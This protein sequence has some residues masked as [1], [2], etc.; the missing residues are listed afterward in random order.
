MGGLLRFY[1]TV[2]A[3]IAVRLKAYD[4]A[5]ELYH[6]VEDGLGSDLKAAAPIMAQGHVWSLKGDHARAKAEFERALRLKPDEAVAH[7]NVGWACDQQGDMDAALVHF[8]RA[9]E[10]N[11]DLDRAWY[12][13][14]VIYVRREQ[15]EEAKKAFQEVVAIEPYNRYGW[16]QLGMTHFVL[17]ETKE[18][19]GLRHHTV[20]FDPKISLY[21]DRDTAKLRAQ[22]KQEQG[23][24]KPER[25][26]AA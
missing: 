1:L 15:H 18:L 7:F 2:A 3:R 10:L 9:I 21:I 26:A 6:S 19:D 8:K 25:A 16:Y 20:R 14:G 23:L 12:G 17:G 22:N 5:L 13:M 4:R 24:Q 11:R